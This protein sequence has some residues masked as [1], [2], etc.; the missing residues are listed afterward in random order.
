MLLVQ[1]ELKVNF[2]GF[3]NAKTSATSFGAILIVVEIRTCARI[4][5]TA[6]S[7]RN[8]VR[9]R[10]YLKMNLGIIGLP[11]D[12]SKFISSFS[13]TLFNRSIILKKK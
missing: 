13:L 7:G 3:Y 10:R 2:N 8:G 4:Y 9:E 11:L 6:P 1:Q 5:G 12:Y